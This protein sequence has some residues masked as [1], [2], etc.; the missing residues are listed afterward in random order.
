[1]Y[2]EA[3]LKNVQATYR[4]YCY[5]AHN[6]GTM[7]EGKLN[8]IPS[9]FH[10]FLCDTVQEFVEK[11][12]NKSFEIL[13]INTPP[14]H[15]KLCADSTPVLTRNGWKNH[16]DLV[17][18]DEVISPS[19][20]FVKVT[21]V[22][23]KQYANRLVTLTN[24]EQIK[25]H[26]NHEWVVYD[27]STHRER[28]RETKYIE[29]RVSYGSQEKK[30][31]HRYN[32]MLPIVTPLDCEEKTLTVD[33]YVLGVW[34]GDGKNTDGQICA[35][36]V[37]RITLDEVRKHYPHGKEWVHKDTG[38][39]YAS[40]RGLYKGLREYGMC[41]SR[42]RTEKHIPQEY[43]TASKRQR[44]ELLAGLI[45]TDGYVDHKHNRIVFTTADTELRFSFEELIA[46]F[47]WRTTTCGYKPVLSTSGI[48]GKNV[49]WQ[50]AFNPTEEIPCRIERKKLK[51]FSQQRRIAICSVEP[52]P[53]E[54]GNCIS[55]EGGVYC[56]GKG[57][58]PTHNSESVTATFPSWYLMRNPDN[59]VICV[60]YGDDLSRRFGKK[61][62]DKIKKY[63]NIF[64][65]K[66]DQNKHNASEFRI[67]GHKGV[68]ISAGYGSGITGNPAKLIVIDDP[69]KNRVE[70]DS[71]KD[72]EKKWADFVDSIESRTANGTKIILIMTRWH[73]D[74]LAGRLIENYGDRTTVVNL[75]CEAE[76]GDPLGRKIGDPL[77]PEIGKGKEWL[78]DF[79]KSHM[80]E[81]GMRSWNALYQGHPSAKEGNI[82]KREWWEYYTEEELEKATFDKIIM[83]VDA[84]FKDSEKNDFVAISV[85]GKR[86]E[87][88]WLL[89]M[90]NKHLN[91]TATVKAI[92]VTRARYIGLSETLIEDTANGTLILQLM[93]DEIAGLIA[94][95]PDVSKEARVNAISF[96]IEAGN[97]R[98]PKFKKF[99]W[100]FVEQCASFPNGKHDDMVDSMSQALN[101]LYFTRTMRRKIK[102]AQN[103]MAGWGIN[104]IP[105]RSATGKGDTVHVI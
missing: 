12:T 77:C 95:K 41:Y 68:M 91:F 105:K 100:E 15:G 21:N 80:T 3:Y 23:P 47:G 52:I 54:Q 17:I 69:V 36:E 67:S 48:Q 53:E 19:G 39:L 61:N 4:Y 6:S 27:R 92:K 58:I 31:G 22:L 46:T 96:L 28:V 2:S 56:V 75:P 81:S 98:L 55:V 66:L 74:D 26:E 8:W 64:G 83:S 73:E 101:R 32:F 16:G 51:S 87:Q 34:L 38:V 14:Q 63:G 82:I 85:W 89:D 97:V 5:H 1:M 62:L 49:Y 79:K 65:V 10:I 72:R 25:V 76:E 104:T 29:K 13:I 45:D 103:K 37:D 9:P 86:G 44:L 30:R 42:K 84:A 43:L 88:Y 59:E 60:S 11:P 102:A 78:K 35:A 90:Q 50:V 20:K 93:K 18:G 99:T 24:G 57:L 7:A 40:Y 94:V 33:P 70:A 71:P